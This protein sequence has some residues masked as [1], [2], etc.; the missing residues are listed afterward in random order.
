LVK[1]WTP[2]AAAAN[3][4]A[5]DYH[6]RTAMNYRTISPLLLGLSFLSVGFAQSES[7]SPPTQDFATVKANHLARLAK[8]LACVQAATSFETMHECMPPPPGGHRGPPPPQD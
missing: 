4:A 1:F 2:L 3:I 6:S 7:S 5:N 8:E